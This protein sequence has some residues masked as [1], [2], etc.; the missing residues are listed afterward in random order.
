MKNYYLLENFCFQL[1][2]D[3]FE[4]DQIKEDLQW[5]D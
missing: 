4:K 2:F 1:D 5:D 3:D